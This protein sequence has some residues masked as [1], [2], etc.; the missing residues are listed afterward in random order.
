M[1]VSSSSHLALRV[2]WR[3]LYDMWH[4]FK[5]SMLADAGLSA[6]DMRQILDTETPT[7]RALYDTTPMPFHSYSEYCTEV[8][9]GRRTKKA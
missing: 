6:E 2:N 1:I 4:R 5:E 7:L 9:S 8:I 3:E